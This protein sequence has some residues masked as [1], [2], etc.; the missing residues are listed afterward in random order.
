MAPCSIVSMACGM[1]RDVTKEE[2]HFR[3]TNRSEAR[4]QTLRLNA[5]ANVKVGVVAASAEV[6]LATST[7]FSSNDLIVAISVSVQTVSK[8]LRSAIKLSDEVA[9]LAVSDPVQF[10]ATCGTRYVSSVT[11]GGQ[12]LIFLTISTTSKEDRSK[13]ETSISGSYASLG[14][15]SVDAARELQSKLTDRRVDL[16]VTRIGGIPRAKPSNPADVVALFEYAN[17]FAADVREAPKV[18]SYVTSP[19]SRLPGATVCGTQY[20]QQTLDL[21]GDAWDRLLEATGTLETYLDAIATPEQFICQVESNEGRRAHV[22]EIVEYKDS[23]EE[24]LTACARL[25]SEPRQDGD[26]CSELKTLL[27]QD[28]LPASLDRWTYVKEF[29]IVMDEDNSP[30]QQ[31]YYFDLPS[32]VCSAPTVNG[33]WSAWERNED[34][35]DPERCFEACPMPVQD[36]A[37]LV[38]SFWDWQPSNNR[39]GCTIRISC[40]DPRDAY[41]LNQCA[42]D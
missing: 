38:M 32:E 17:M 30:G 6:G 11:E 34:C 20:D 31:Y 27:E 41:L 40:Q 3:T 24:K 25:I 19:Y 5:K 29:T 42:S 13:L 26:A 39:G 36:G 21:I 9:G 12:L 18:I 7:K 14:S 8:A 22:D 15:L 4:S 33:T 10:S 37:Q 2:G 1:F 35:D 28:S 16:K 23:L